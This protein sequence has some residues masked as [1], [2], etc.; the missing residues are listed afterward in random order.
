MN[1]GEE[2]TKIAMIASD[3]G[4][5]PEDI[6]SFFIFDDARVLAQK[7]M[8]VHIIRSRYEDDF[9]AY[10]I[11]YHSL[12]K[13]MNIGAIIFALKN[14]HSYPL[15]AIRHPESI[16]WENLYALI[17]S[18]NVLKNN[19][20]L[21]HGQFAYPG[22]VVGLLAKRKTGRPLVVSLYGYD[23][24]VVKEAGYGLRLRKR[25]DVLVRTALKNADAVICVSSDLRRKAMEMGVPEEKLYTLFVTTNTDKFRPPT[26]QDS[27]ELKE[28]RKK[29][30]VSEE[31]FLILNARHL[32]AIYGIEYLVK[33]AKLVTERVKNAK[34]II[35]GEGDLYPKL[36]SLISELGLHD[37]VKLVGVVPKQ[38]MPKLMQACDIYVNTSLS[39]GTSPSLIEASASGKPIVSFNVGG[40]ADIIEHGITGL[41]V[42]PKNLEELAE[43]IVQ[44]LE[45]PGTLK[46][47]GVKARRRAE[48]KFDEKK[49]I[50]ELMEIYRRV[51]S[52]SRN[53]QD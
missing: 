51:I 3:V 21:I 47:M 29:F 22:G 19:I 4:K 26:K 53:V 24:N 10:G 32:T 28:I 37:N 35:A 25:T 5:S 14:I 12:R 33:A 36:S 45:N 2:Q 13:K 6:G 41:L 1:I 34:F 52:T 50:P 16:Y 15:I 20:D 23:M 46:E 43:R 8:E 9:T 44:I 11:R 42:Q 38:M 39:D 49:R 40:A 30:G 18:E 31:D 17:V 27:R 7:G 48:D